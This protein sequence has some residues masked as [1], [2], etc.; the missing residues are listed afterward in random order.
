MAAR[1]RKAELN[2]LSVELHRARVGAP[3]V[4]EPADQLSAEAEALAAADLAA[5]SAA[6]LAG[7]AGEALSDAKDR[8]A[9]EAGAAV[10]GV[11]RRIET[12]VI[13][14]PLAGVAVAFVVGLMLGRGWGRDR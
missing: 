5:E 11:K 14:R 13:A 7:R 4:A 3:P 9:G 12:A 1:S 2:A 6:E 8:I 10:A